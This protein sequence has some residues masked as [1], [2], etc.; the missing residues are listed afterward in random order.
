MILDRIKI[1][2]IKN[3]FDRMVEMNTYERFLINLLRIHS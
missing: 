1:L 2:L 3:R